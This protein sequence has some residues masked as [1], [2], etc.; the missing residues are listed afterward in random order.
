MTRGAFAILLLLFSTS[1]A[2]AQS[3]LGGEGGELPVTVEAEDGIEWR[4]EERQYIA[5]GNARATRG[6]LTLDADTLTALYRDRA[7]AS[8]TEIYRIIGDGSVVITSPERTARGE[9]VVYDIDQAV[10]VLTGNGLRMV[11]AEETITARDSLEYWQGLDLAVARGAASATRGERTI[12]ADVLTARF[13][14]T[15][16]GERALTRMEAIGTVV[17]TTPQ[18]VVRGNEGVYDVPNEIA[19]L[20]GDVRITRGDNQLNGEVARVNL[21]TGVSRLLSAGAGK[22]RVQGLF[23]PEKKN[24]N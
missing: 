24:E 4:R 20:R 5:R 13:T 3:V 8:G 12:E 15:G 23:K 9:R 21:K 6:E 7:N 10:A 19:T 14:E 18:E 11:S 17:I 1:T 2:A 16:S 22:A